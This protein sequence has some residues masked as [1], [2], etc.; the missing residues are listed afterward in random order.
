MI[1]A[2]LASPIPGLVSFGSA[3]LDEKSTITLSAAVAVV[4]STWRMG[5]KFQKFLDSQKSQSA[6]LQRVE[7]TIDK[8]EAKVDA[9]AQKAEEENRKVNAKIDEL[10]R[11]RIFDLDNLRSELFI[12]G[13]PPEPGQRLKILLVDDDQ[14]DRELMRR[15]LSGLYAIEESPSL[16]NAIEKAKSAHY[17]CVLLDLYLP[18][19]SPVDTVAR[20]LGENPTA[21]CMALSGSQEHMNQAVKQGADSFIAKGNYDRLY[22]SRMIQNAINRKR[23]A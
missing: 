21:V 20:F 3:A 23:L 18:D 9:Q 22:L 6:R 2:L 13:H 16:S 17:D 1:F 15:A 4:V 12:R 8:V 19:S 11:Q 7:Q 10:G 14:T 5:R